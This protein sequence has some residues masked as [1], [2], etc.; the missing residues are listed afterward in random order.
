[1]VEFNED[2]V[3]EIL[4]H[5]WTLHFTSWDQEFR[6][7]AFRRFFIKYA[8]ISK[9]WTLPSEVYIYRST[10]LKWIHQWHSFHAGLSNPQ[11]GEAL[12]SC[13]RVLEISLSKR[14]LGIPVTLL[15]TIL[16]SLP[17][18]VEL[19]LRIGIGVDTLY[20]I[21]PLKDQLQSTFSATFGSLRALQ[22]LVHVN[23]SKTR[24]IHE[25]KTLTNE[26]DLD[27]FTLATNVDNPA[28]PVFDPLRYQSETERNSETI[29]P[30]ETNS[31]SLRFS[32]L[33][34]AYSSDSRKPIVV[35]ET[36]RVHREDDAF[37]ELFNMLAPHI[38]QL[39][40]E[41]WSHKTEW[42]ESLYRIVS[43][44][45]RLERLIIC[46]A[47]PNDQSTQGHPSL[48]ILETQDWHKPEL[49]RGDMDLSDGN[50]DVF[51]ISTPAQKPKLI[52]EGDTI[53]SA[54]H[55]VCFP[56]E[57]PCVWKERT[58]YYQKRHRRPLIRDPRPIREAFYGKEDEDLYTDYPGVHASSDFHEFLC[59]AIRRPQV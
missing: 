41:V 27:F 46:Q 23:S 38:K 12:K 6:P 32:D 34:P 11:R 5:L 56:D 44:C 10:R 4:Q 39:L 59:A 45:H 24:V 30:I 28:L 29:W 54:L 35:P 9:V 51:D 13:V 47:C 19:Q 25:I 36:M 26:V 8:L 40:Y 18:L 57:V 15:P 14:Q 37:H 43:N 31:Y 49:S 3:R 22:V 53:E 42:D 33:Y 48:L 17:H 20:P 58:G 2:V 16:R 21:K 1:M 50:P 55:V 7:G 52:E